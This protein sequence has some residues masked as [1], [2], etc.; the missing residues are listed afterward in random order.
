MK[1]DYCNLP[2]L[3]TNTQS[4]NGQILCIPIIYRNLLTIQDFLEFSS[5]LLHWSVIESLDRWWG[6]WELQL[7]WWLTL[8]L[9]LFGLFPQLGL[10]LKFCLLLQFCLPL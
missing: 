9:V 10:L 1:L 7:W 5:F 3:R 4:A 2:C 6:L 8:D